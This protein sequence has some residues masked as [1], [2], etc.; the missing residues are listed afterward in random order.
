MKTQPSIRPETLFLVLMACMG[1][2][3]TAHARGTTFTC[4][5]RLDSGGSPA[6]GSFDFQF[7]LHDAASGG[8]QWGPTLTNTAVAVSN[9][10]CA[11]SPDFGRWVFEGSTHRLETLAMR[12]EFRGTLPRRFQLRESPWLDAGAVVSEQTRR[13]TGG[14]MIGLIIHQPHGKGALRGEAGV[15][16]A[17][18]GAFG[19]GCL[20]TGEP[21]GRTAASG[22]ACGVGTCGFPARRGSAGV[23]DRS[24]RRSR[25]PVA[26]MDEI[27]LVRTRAGRV[28]RLSRAGAGPMLARGAGMWSVLKEFWAFARREKKWWLIPLV[29]VLLVLGAVLIFTSSGGIVWALYP[30]M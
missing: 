20:R 14:R 4:Q 15:E 21:T 23:F 5:G 12:T 8:N 30:F 22:R 10:L 1:Q 24:A 2:G 25:P 6:N 17:A 7:A 16:R 13:L 27:A 29:V 9:G 3:A 18:G 26:H 11:M 19:D 28:W